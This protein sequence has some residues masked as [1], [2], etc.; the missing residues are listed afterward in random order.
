MLLLLLSNNDEESSSDD[1]DTDDGIDDDED[2][3]VYSNEEDFT[4]S[5]LATNCPLKVASTATTK[6]QIRMVIC[7]SVSRQEMRE[8]N[9]K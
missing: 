7:N 9:Y 2:D 5:V 3:V 6:S 4:S 8:K 1:D